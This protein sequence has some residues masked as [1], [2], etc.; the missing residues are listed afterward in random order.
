MY[1]LSRCFGGL[2][3]SHLASTPRAHSLIPGIP[4]PT[5]VEG[6]GSLD[7]FIQ[8]DGL[9]RPT[10]YMYLNY[11]QYG[12]LFSMDLSSNKNE[13]VIICD[14]NDYAKVLE[15]EGDFPKGSV[16]GTEAHHRFYRDHPELAEPGILKVGPEWKEARKVAQ[17]AMLTVDVAKRC[18]PLLENCVE[19]A[20]A[21]LPEFFGD[22]YKPDDFWNYWNRVSLDMFTNVMLGVDKKFSAKEVDPHDAENIQNVAF[23]IDCVGASL[24]KPWTLDEIYPA[25]EKSM[26]KTLDF[27]GTLASEVYSNPDGVSEDTV[28]GRMIKKG[29]PQDKLVAN[30]N[31]FLMAA[32]DTTAGLSSWILLNLA[33]FPEKQDILHK[34]LE[35]VL[36]GGHPTGE[37]IEQLPYLK[38][39]FR[40]S[41]RYSNTNVVNT[42]RQLQQPITLGGCEIPAETFL[43]M[44][45]HP[46]QNDP[47]YVDEPHLFQPERFLPAAKK[48]RKGTPA[49]VIDHPLIRG[50]FSGGKRMCIGARTSTAEILHMT[51]RLFQDYRITIK[52]DCTDQYKFAQ[53]GAT[54]SVAEAFP[55]L[56]FER[57]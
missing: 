9:A 31:L 48:A 41:F 7:H 53:F 1:R 56:H 22:E 37:T 6:S 14:P 43:M 28:L 47:Q 16:S 42:M 17:P 32:V 8:H 33:R 39:V 38:A 11:K 49:A 25:Y 54:V 19:R 26:L 4:G 55:K 18:Y 12:K 27:V 3:A 2:S 44:C 21:N 23:T 24:M 20:S 29:M 13:W 45:T 15:V 34:E 50:P 40:E 5:L 51:S 35:G 36:K 10:K 52:E 46:M 57:R 30:M